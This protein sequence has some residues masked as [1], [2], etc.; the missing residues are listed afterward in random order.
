MPPKF[1]LPAWRGRQLLCSAR[2]SHLPFRKRLDTGR[3]RCGCWSCPDWSRQGGVEVGFGHWG[4]DYFRMGWR[5]TY[6]LPHDQMNIF[7]NSGA[8]EFL[9]GGRG[10]VFL[11]LCT[12]I[13][14]IGLKQ[15]MGHN[16]YSV[17]PWRVQ[18]WM[19]PTTSKTTFGKGT[20]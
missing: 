13:S 16:W 11:M 9:G 3:R 12:L 1:S 4:G 14:V 18:I 5:F 15:K 19:G 8:C 7:F 6:G 10:D 2:R 17:C 20:Y